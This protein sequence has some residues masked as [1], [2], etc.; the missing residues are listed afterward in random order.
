MGLRDGDG[1]VDCDCG[2]RHWGRFGAAGLLLVRRDTPQPQVLL[3]LRAEWTHG[4]GTWALP[5]GAKDSH[6]DSVTAAL[7]EAH[8]EM[9][10]EVAAL[11]VKHIFSDNHGPWS[12]D[13]IIA[14]SMND[15]GAHIANPESTATKWSLIEEVE[16]LN[17]HPGLKQSWVA[18]KP[19]TISSLES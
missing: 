6:E 2:F 11:T 15:A 13:T 9:G 17:L 1:W 19:L 3:Q 5:G 18:L 8:E 12:Y 7:R 4:G 14:H 16:T 10:I